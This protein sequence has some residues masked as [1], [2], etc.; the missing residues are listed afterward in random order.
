MSAV[1]QPRPSVFAVPDAQWR[2]W[3][4]WSDISATTDAELVP[5]GARVVVLAA[6]PG[7]ETLACG[8]LL[9]HVADRGDAVVVLSVTDGTASHPGSRRWPAWRLMA[10]RPREARAALDALGLPDAQI[11][12]AA[13][14]DGQVAAHRERLVHLLERLVRP[15]D[16]IVSPWRRDGDADA[17]AI[18]DCAATVAT[19][20]ASRFIEVPV[21]A[22]RGATPGD[23]AWPWLRARQLPIAPELAR[24]KT[25][26]LRELHSQIEPDIASGAAPVMGIDVLQRAAWTRELYFV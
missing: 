23:G 16:V 21:S 22:W 14:P 26:A 7:D 3:D 1:L 12:R 2:S 5:T 13:L 18:A 6:R 25:R 24:R 20:T 19:H 11:V 15:L 10:E 9:R 17:L 8:G 4:G